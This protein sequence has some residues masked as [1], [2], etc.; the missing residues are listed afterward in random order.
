MTLRAAEPVVRK[1]KVL[2]GFE[3]VP[4]KNSIVSVLRKIVGFARV[5]ACQNASG[6]GSIYLSHRVYRRLDEST[7]AA[8]H[9]IS[10]GGKSCAAGADR[11]P[12]HAFYRSSALA[13]GSESQKAQPESLGAGRDNRDAGDAI[14]VAPEIDRHEIRWQQVQKS[15]TST[16][17]G[18][19]FGS[20]RPYG[21]GKPRVGLSA[22]SG[23][24]IESR[25]HRRSYHNCEHSQTSWHRAST[26]AKP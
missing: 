12:P 21:R 6:S 16:N 8:S 22:D 9:R 11:Q 17:C 20:C 4:S 23:S 14:G 2:R 19:H 25:S 18:G 3:P 10:D 13:A 7:P 26:G 24:I 1:N 15:R 5:V